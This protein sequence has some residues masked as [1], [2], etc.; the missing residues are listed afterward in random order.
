MKVILFLLVAIAP[1]GFLNDIAEINA[2]KEEAR[3]AYIS[4]DYEAAIT[5]YNTLINAYGV[6]DDDVRL[7][8]A[9]AQFKNKDLQGALDNYTQVLASPDAQI[10]SSAYNQMGLIAHQ[11]KKLKEALSYF[12]DALKADENNEEA[13]YNYS[14]VKKELEQQQKQENQDKQ[15]NKDKQQQEQNK[16]KKE[17]EGDSKEEQKKEEGEGEQKEEK[18]G[19]EKQDAE[20]EKQ[21]EQKPGE[22]GQEKEQQQGEEQEDTEQMPQSTAERLEEMS[23][24]KEKAQMILEAMKNNE[25]QY[26]QQNQRKSRTKADSDKP[27]W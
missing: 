16:E 27:Y 18:E 25:I 13:R 21:D 5:K 10:R 20:Q 22:Q 15:Q 8:L 3:E 4:G 6:Q 14:V 17:Q 24:P 23:I 12:K 19:E 11:Q 2:L 1:L 9:H 7:N 26:L